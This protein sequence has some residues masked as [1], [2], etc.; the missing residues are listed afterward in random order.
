M[1]NRDAEQRLQM[2]HSILAERQSET[3]SVDWYSI[4]RRGLFQVSPE[5][6]YG[7]PIAPSYILTDADGRPADLQRL[8]QASRPDLE[9]TQSKFGTITRMLRP[10]MVKE[11]VDQE[12]E[13]WNKQRS[14][15]GVANAERRAT[16]RQAQD[17]YEAAKSM[18]EGARESDRALLER[19]RANYELVAFMENVDADCAIAVEEYCDLIMMSMAY[20][21][22]ICCNWLLRYLPDRRT[23]HILLD[24]P[25]LA[26]LDLPKSWS[27]STKDAE[28]LEQRFTE[29]ELA[30]L[31]DSVCYQM[32]MRTMYDLFLADE[33]GVLDSITCNGEVAVQSPSSAEATSYIVLSVSADKQDVLAL[34][35]VNE[36]ASQLFEQLGGVS[37]GAP[38]LVMPVEAVG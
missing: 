8:D 36:S 16:L 28:V 20:P 10:G 5:D 17:I 7:I 19:V 35:I 2:L 21:D 15:I 37:A 25:S 22:E 14:D 34:D 3:I 32:V 4:E 33:A 38:H 24:L 26:Q 1:L 9:R 13:H 30:E 18:F 23:L 31:C 6:L 27:Y 29:S 12:I 11:A